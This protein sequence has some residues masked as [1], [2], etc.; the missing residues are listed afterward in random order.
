MV[1]AASFPGWWAGIGIG[2]TIVVVVVILVSF[3][4]T[5]A[6]RIR[7]QAIEGI[8]R[9]DMARANTVSVWRIQEIN[10]STTGIWRSAER[11]RK[12]LEGGS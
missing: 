10:V 11:A 2:F 5:Y 1:L 3:I 4:L 7:D 6:A 12:I 8:W 9:M